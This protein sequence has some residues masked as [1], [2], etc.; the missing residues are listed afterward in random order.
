MIHA[1]R[2][3]CFTDSLS[4]IPHAMGERDVPEGGE[5][6]TVRCRCGR[7]FT[8]VGALG[9]IFW[10]PTCEL[11]FD[12]ARYVPPGAPDIPEAPKRKYIVL[13]DVTDARR[14]LDALDRYMDRRAGTSTGTPAHPPSETPPP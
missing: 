12:S 8:L 10:R 1:T 13:A 6:R 9:F 4:G 14:K 7:A 11:P 3:D 2:S 5:G